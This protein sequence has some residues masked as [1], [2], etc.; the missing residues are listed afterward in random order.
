MS[1]NIFDAHCDTLLRKETHKS[2]VDGGGSLHVDLPSLLESGVGDQV[3]AVCIKP[4]TGIEREMWNIGLK[5][6]RQLMYTRKPRFHFALEGCFALS[7]GWELPFHPLVAS[8]TWNGDNLYAGGIG[9]QMDLTAQGRKLVKQFT[10]ENTAIDVSHLND[11]SRKSLLQLGLPVCATH[12]NARAL[13]NG[14]NRNLPDEDI[15]EIAGRGGVVGIT[16]VPEFL[17]ND[18]A[19]ATIE[20]VLN[21]ME[22]VA[23]LTSIDSVGF[24]SDFDGV[25]KL[26]NGIKGAGSWHKVLYGLE[27]R[28]WSSEDIDKAAGGNWRRFFKLNKEFSG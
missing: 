15:V 2:F 28:G 7:K 21:H 9:S 10:L 8:L 11:R 20:S 12:S 27:N 13:C 17:E 1:R 3:M 26:P 25:G 18:G 24:G 16:F 19:D 5:N 14:H 4:Y 22:Y 6:Y 23:E